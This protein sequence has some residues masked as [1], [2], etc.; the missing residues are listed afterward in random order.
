MRSEAIVEIEG[1]G[2]GGAAGG[3][4][5]V[6]VGVGPALEQRAN[7]TFGLSVGLGPVGACLSDADL[8]SGARFG[9]ASLEAFAVVGQHAF[10]VDAVLAVEA[11]E[12]G[13]EGE[14]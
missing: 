12:L 9:P 1:L 13:E 7:E 4:V 10:D 11:D 14:R 5:V 2:K 6:A 8:V 3:F